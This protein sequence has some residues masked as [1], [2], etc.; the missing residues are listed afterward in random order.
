MRW[1]VG[2]GLG[3]LGA[4]GLGGLGA[5]RP[6]GLTGGGCLS[7]SSSTWVSFVRICHLHPHVK[8]GGF[9]ILC[10]VV[11]ACIIRPPNTPHY[12]KH[13]CSS[14][15]PTACWR[16]T[17]C[18][19]SA[20]CCLHRCHHQRQELLQQQRL[21]PLPSAPA[22]AI[23]ISSSSSCTTSGGWPEKMSR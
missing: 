22:A 18:A 8:G 11:P 1:G 19:L 5:Y 4:W 9:H 16:A 15:P 3:G 6:V 17:W 23:E 13:S 21:L 20:G 2:L 14:A 10:G 7:L 12:H